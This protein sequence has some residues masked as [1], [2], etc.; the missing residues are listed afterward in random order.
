MPHLSATHCTHKRATPKDLSS[1]L[2][3]DHSEVATLLTCVVLGA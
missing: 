2:G 1:G 3:E